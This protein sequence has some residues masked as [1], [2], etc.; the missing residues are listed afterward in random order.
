MDLSDSVKK[1]RVL[2]KAQYT[3]RL[4]R[5]LKSKKAQTVAASCTRGLR[6][7]CREVLCKKGAATH[8]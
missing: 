3:A 5:V 2:S 4:K 8:G 1:A 7:V 6:K